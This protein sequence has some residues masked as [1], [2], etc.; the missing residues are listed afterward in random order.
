M[1]AREKFKHAAAGSEV[2]SPAR[3]RLL[4]A[5]EQLFMERGYAGVTLRDVSAVVG[6]KQG[7]LYH[8]A[9][10]GKEELY[11]SVMLR[12]IERHH[13]AMSAMIDVID[14]PFEEC[15]VRLGMWLSAEPPLN[16]SRVLL[17]D[18]P[19]I[20][21]EQANRIRAAL[22]SQANAPLMNLIERAVARGEL[23]VT[24]VGLVVGA[25]R[26]MMQSTG[27][28]M[29]VSGKTREHIVRS[30]VDVLLRGILADNKPP[31]NVSSE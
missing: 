19:H 22:I 15:F 1:S 4:A 17:S 9:P 30:A 12:A 6:I 8:H 11:V 18:L 29:A 3:D 14:G 24:N 26:S 7:S 27:L 5:A 13:S 16:V 21:P 28:A 10:G 31:D 23:R 2:G 25:F 20:S